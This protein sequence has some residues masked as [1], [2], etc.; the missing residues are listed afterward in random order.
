MFVCL[1]VGLSVDLSVI[2]SLQ[3][4]CC[5]QSTCYILLF[6]R[7]LT[8]SNLRE[9]ESNILFSCS[10]LLFI[11]ELLLQKRL[12]IQAI[13]SI[14]FNLGRLKMIS[15][16]VDFKFRRI[17]FIFPIKVKWIQIIGYTN[18]KIYYTVCSLILHS[19]INNI[20]L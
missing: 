2:I 4:L 14:F 6:V 20:K 18:K 9:V 3:F 13:E 15:Y 5:Y 8:E 10:C 16:S 12:S 1:L 7:N 11:N 19:I 17:V